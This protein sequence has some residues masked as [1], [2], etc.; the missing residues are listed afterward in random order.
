MITTHL[1]LFSFLDGATQTPA[2]PDSTDGFI[3]HAGVYAF[4]DGW[5]PADAEVVT[6]DKGRDAGSGRR[7]QWWEGEW[8]IP[9][10][11][12]Y[13]PE[14][15]PEDIVP[16]RP[17]IE[18]IKARLAALPDPI[19]RLS[20]E[21][22]GI[23]RSVTYLERKAKAIVDDTRMEET[24]REITAQYRVIQG[25]VSNA[26]RRVEA[27]EIMVARLERLAREDDEFLLI[28]QTGLD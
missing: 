24:I 17:K 12:H 9:G 27:Q 26:E 11:T 10:I 3:T 2:A 16:L 25:K 23:T 28:I 14:K 8:I 7:K 5:S 6:I 21:L 20:R 1:V 22:A 13:L 18:E 4:F 19:P 15:P